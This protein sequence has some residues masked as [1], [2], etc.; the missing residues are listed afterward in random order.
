MRPG[1]VGRVG[2]SELAVDPASA[3][4]NESF[5]MGNLQNSGRATGMT[6]VSKTSAPDAAPSSSTAGG[7]Q[8]FDR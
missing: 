7:C 2:T 6:V 8:R 4:R 5:S 3:K 1:M